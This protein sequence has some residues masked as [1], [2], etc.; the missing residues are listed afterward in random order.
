VT[1]EP[2]QADEPYAEIEALIKSLGASMTRLAY[3]VL[4][5]YPDADDAVQNACVDVYRTWSTVG[6]L[7]TPAKQRAYLRRAVLN[8]SYRIWG[9]RRARQEVLSE[10][11]ASAWVVEW[12]AA[13]QVSAKIDLCRV[14]RAIA[15]LPDACGEVMSLYIAGHDYGEIATMVGI[16]VSA[17]RSHMSHGRQRL[18]AAL[19]DVWEE[20]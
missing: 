20:D 4:R 3:G 8:A 6:H 14:W 12:D 9:K 11:A 7:E 10:Q 13:G 19:P 1:S 16:S 15:E 5:S 18:R 17:V 2:G